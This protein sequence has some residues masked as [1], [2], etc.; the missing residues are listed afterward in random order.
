MDRGV[1]TTTKS[2]EAFVIGNQP[3]DMQFKDT[4]ETRFEGI[5]PS[6]RGGWGEP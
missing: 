4:I 6:P 5:V 1:L 3:S 2:L